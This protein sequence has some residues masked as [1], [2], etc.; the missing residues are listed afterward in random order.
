MGLEVRQEWLAGFQI[1]KSLDNQTEER[2]LSP[3]D[4]RCRERILT[5]GGQSLIWVLFSYLD[6][7]WNSGNLQR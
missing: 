7:G 2:I 4:T 5:R 1:K 3:M 6:Q